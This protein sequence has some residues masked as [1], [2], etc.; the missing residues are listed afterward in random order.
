MRQTFFHTRY[1]LIENKDIVK[2]AG[3]VY[4]LSVWQDESYVTKIGITHNCRCTAVEVLARKNTQSDSATAIQK[5][6]KAT[7]QIGKSGKN[8][9][10]MFRFNPGKDKRLFPENNAYN[11]KHCDGGK[12]NLSALI[13]IASI[14]LSLEDEKCRAKK[15]LE[16]A[17]QN[18]IK[19]QRKEIKQ[20]AKE[21]LIGKTVVHPEIKSPITFTMKGIDEAL[22]QPHKHYE[23]KN[24]SIKDIERLIQK[25]EYLKKTMNTKNS[26]EMMHYFKVEIEKEDS[27]LVIKE[28]LDNNTFNFYSIV[29]RLKKKK[30]L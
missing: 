20:W 3:K 10:E 27:F 30:S 28:N 2:Y 7:T 15:L 12:V 18:P 14:V 25:S 19:A 4:N 8:K 13:G 17:S 29:D 16:E 1:I 22:N 21:N 5:G 9:A 26:R 24:E 11:P 6:E 23:Q